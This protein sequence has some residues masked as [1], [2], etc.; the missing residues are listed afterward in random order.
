MAE[1]DTDA[2]KA[3]IRAQALVPAYAFRGVC[4][5]VKRARCASIWSPVGRSTSCAWRRL[6][7]NISRKSKVA[8]GRRQF[9]MYYMYKLVQIEY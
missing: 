6:T 4:N 3:A 5:K 8:M 9:R 7:S 2:V 1:F